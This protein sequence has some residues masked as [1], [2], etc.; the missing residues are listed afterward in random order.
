MPDL[1]ETLLENRM[2][3]HPNHA[4]MLETAH[5]GNIL[6]WMDEVGGMSAM[7]FAGRACVTAQMDQVSF[8]Q[9]IEVGDIALVRAYVYDAGETSVRVRLQTFCEDP[10]TGETALTTESYAIYVAIDDDREPTGVPDLTVSSERG[11]RLREDALNGD[12]FDA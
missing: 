4:N 9:P 6:K 5:G 1:L 7:R 3:V 8:T 2:F 11:R 12:D 10:A